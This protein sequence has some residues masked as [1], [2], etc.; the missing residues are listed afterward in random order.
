MTPDDGVETRYPGRPYRQVHESE[1]TWEPMR[2]LP[3]GGSPT[4][5][6]PGAPPADGKTT[7][8]SAPP[9]PVGTGPPD[10]SVTIPVQNGSA[11][12]GPAPWWER[13]Q[14]SPQVRPA[15]RE[16]RIALWGATSSGKT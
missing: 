2:Q 15:E 4:R 5:R 12:D 14:S 7:E 3:A 11:P 16:T 8:F 6:M 10:G 9:R 13:T 1:G